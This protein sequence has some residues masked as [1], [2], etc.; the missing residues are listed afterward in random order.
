ME[1]VFWAKPQAN[2]RHR[3][4]AWERYYKSVLRHH[5]VAIEYIW[6]NSEGMLHD[7]SKIK[8]GDKQR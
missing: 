1:Q 7:F 3:S 2:H 6:F 5:K 8:C 4:A